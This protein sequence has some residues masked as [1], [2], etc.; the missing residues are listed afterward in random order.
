MMKN[1][2]H[3]QRKKSWNIQQLQRGLVWILK[4]V[5]IKIFTSISVFYH[6]HNQLS[7]IECLQ[8]HTSIILQFRTIHESPWLKP[9]FSRAAFLCYA[10][11]RVEFLSFPLSNFQRLTF[12]DL[13]SLSF[14]FWL[15]SHPLSH[16]TFPSE[17]SFSS[18]VS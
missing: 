4:Y 5:P 11:S 18:Q 1:C 14:V 10:G 16:T 2:P 17:S 15:A 3:H 6:C 12:L 9:R 8:P 7:Q 13:K